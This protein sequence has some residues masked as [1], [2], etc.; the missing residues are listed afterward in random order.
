VSDGAGGGALLIASSTSITLNGAISTDGGN[1]V[2]R[3]SSRRVAAVAQFALSPSRLVG[4]EC[5]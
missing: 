1:Q 2:I 4:Q 3:P 5:Y